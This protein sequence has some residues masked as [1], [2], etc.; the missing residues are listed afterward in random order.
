MMGRTNILLPPATRVPPAC[1]EP[2]AVGA[3]Q[4]ADPVP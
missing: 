1:L 2:D 4:S 3:V